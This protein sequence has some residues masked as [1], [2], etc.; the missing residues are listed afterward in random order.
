MTEASQISS[1][2]KNKAIQLTIVQSSDFSSTVAP[3]QLDSRAIHASANRPATDHHLGFSK[4][5]T[6]VVPSAPLSIQFRKMKL[7]EGIRT[8]LAACAAFGVSAFLALHF[9][10]P[11]LHTKFVF[12]SLVCLIFGLAMIP[13]TV[14]NLFGSLRLDSRGV[15]VRNGF[16]RTSIP[17]H[18]LKSWG[19]S[20]SQFQISG[21]NT[22]RPVLVCLSRMTPEF[23]IEVRDMLRLCAPEKERKA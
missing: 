6:M 14:T 1:H 7:V 4:H 20:G 10:T 9:D 21:D 11:P 17:W 3:S 19:F 16:S 12:V 5:V 15:H 13:W 8:G 2:P 22:S 23:R 18:E